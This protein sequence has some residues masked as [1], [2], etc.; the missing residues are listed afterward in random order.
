ME[1]C[2]VGHASLDKPGSDD[3]HNPL[4][5]SSGCGPAWLLQRCGTYPLELTYAI[6]TITNIPLIPVDQPS[7]RHNNFTY[8]RIHLLIIASYSLIC[9]FWLLFL[10]NT[11]DLLE[12]GASHIK[13]RNLPIYILLN[14]SDSNFFQISHHNVPTSRWMRLSAQLCLNSELSAS[15]W[16]VLQRPLFQKPGIL[17]HE[18]WNDSIKKL[19]SLSTT[20][21]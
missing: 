5:A 2:W 10:F 8:L 4:G 7:S 16:A 15:P 14:T 11:I 12:T 1:L 6:W 20:F 18:T 21:C 3:V 17:F 9:V 19:L 13:V